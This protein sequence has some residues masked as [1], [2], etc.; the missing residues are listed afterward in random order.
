MRFARG[1]SSNHIRFA[2]ASILALAGS[3]ASA[4]EADALTMESLAFAGGAAIG[5]CAGPFLST[6][7]RY[8]TFTCVSDDIVQG[9]ANERSDTFIKDRN[10]GA[11]ERVSVDS[12]EQEYRFGSGGG[13]P[14]VDG[15]YVVFTSAAPL[16]PDLTFTY[17]G[18]GFGNPFLRDRQLGTTELLGRTA[19]GGFAPQTGS[20]QLTGVSFATNRVLFT[21]SS[22][23]IDAS[24]PAIPRPTQV[25]VRDWK[26]GVVTL[27]TRTPSGT[28]SMGNASAST[29][30][31]D[32]RWVAFI[33]YASD[34]GPAN[35]SETEQLMLHDLTTGLTKRLSY[36][37]TG[38]EFSGN[39]YYQGSGGR[40]SADGQ[41]LVVEANSDELG[42]GD[43]VGFSDIYVVH[44][45]TGRY[46]LVSTGF[47]DAR[48]DN[49]S[50]WPSISADG[51]YVSFFSRA[52][53]LLPIPQVPSVYVKDRLTGEIVNVSAPLG[54]PRNFWVSRTDISADGTTVAFDWRHPDADPTVGSR[55]LVY[56]AQLRGSPVAS[57]VAI[58][59]TSP[60]TLLLGAV[61]LVLA[62]VFAI[63]HRSGDQAN[64]RMQ[65]GA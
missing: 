1:T 59:A 57:S 3:P 36:T 48:P 24:T 52:S 64:S 56:S 62:G 4:L 21:S 25:Y 2:A 31:A 44:T 6:T 16:H 39:P 37:Q 45:Q 22:N 30:S 23:M 19:A 17:T 14:S 54:A 55:T 49:A 13:F 60:R 28:F 10:T 53:N 58:P 61:A 63:R 27:V 18:F 41:L 9:D 33:T 51:R 8:L 34:L 5:P 43:A 47:N 20:A 15:R 65:K 35:P 26:T 42:P 32:G 46:E 40:F 38:G 50:F 12:N 7:A 11:V 29:L